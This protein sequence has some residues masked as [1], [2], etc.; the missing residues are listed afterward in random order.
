MKIKEDQNK[1]SLSSFNFNFNDFNQLLALS[2]IQFDFFS[3][4]FFQ[5]IYALLSII[6]LMKINLK[7]IFFLCILKNYIFFLKNTNQ[8]IYISKIIYTKFIKLI[9][10]QN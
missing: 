9:Q 6:S 3:D 4:Q 2:F 8:K 10:N 1:L 7:S 5:F